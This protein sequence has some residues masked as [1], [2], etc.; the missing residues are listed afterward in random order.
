MGM[1]A[2]MR[3]AGGGLPADE[4]DLNEFL[5]QAD[6]YRHS[7]NVLDEVL[8]VLNTLRMTHPFLVMRA[9]LLRDWIEEGA[10]DRIVRGEYLRRG[11]ARPAWTDDVGGAVRHYTGRAQDTAERAGEAAR[12]MKEAFDRGFKSS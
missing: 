2:L 4:M 7:G 10:Y 11:D 8:K 1:S 3:I 5:V 12:K 9:A 6:E